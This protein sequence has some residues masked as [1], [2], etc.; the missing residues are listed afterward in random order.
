MSNQSFTQIPASRSFSLRLL[1]LLFGIL[2]SASFQESFAAGRFLADPVISEFGKTNIHIFT[3]PVV[4][5][6]PTTVQVTPGTFNVP[7][8][9]DDV[10]GDE[11]NSF[12]FE[13]VFDPDVIEPNGPNFGCSTAGTIAAGYSVACNVFPAGHLLV[14]VSNPSAG[15]LSGS[16]T[17][18]NIGFATHASAIDGEISPLTFTANSVK[19]FNESL[20]IVP[21]TPVNGQIT[22]VTNHTITVTQSPNGT[23]A[24]G[25]TVVPYGTNQ[26]FTITPAAN[27]HIAD[28]KVD[29]VSIGAV[30]NHPFFNVIADH[31]I[32]AIFAINTYPITATSGPNGAVTPPGI[33]NVPFGASQEYT[34]TPGPDYLIEDVLVD[35]VSVGAVASH[36][37][38]NVTAAH[39]ISATFKIK[40]FSL[41]VSKTG[42]GIGTVAS[43]A[44]GIDCGD[45]CAKTY[46]HGTVVTLTATP[47]TGS[48][49]TGWSGGGCSGT[50]TC[51]VTITAPTTVTATF[52]LQTF[53]L[54]VNR[55]GTGT[56]IVV[57]TPPGIDCSP[58][59]ADCFELYDY[60][61]VVTLTATPNI[62][63]IFTGW[64]G[65]CP[66]TGTC[67]VTMTS[68]KIVNANFTIKTFA[69]TVVSAGNGGGLVT[70]SP[71]G[72][73]CGAD[74]TATYN[75]GTQVT[76]TAV[77][78]AN[79]IFTGWSGA[80]S[81][82]STCVITMNAAATATAT[83]TL[84]TFD[85]TVIRSGTGEGSVTSSP[86]GINCGTDCSQTYNIGT[87]VTL[88]ATANSGTTF[89][90]WTG[91]GCTGTATC[92]VTMNAAA[93]VTATF[94]RI[95]QTL[96][97][98]KSGNGF[99]TITSSPAGINCG[100]N[101]PTASA[102]FPIDSQVTLTVAPNVG[103][104][105]T[106]WSGGGCSGT[107]TCVVT[108]NAATTV[109]AG[110]V[111]QTFPLSVVKAGTGA[112]TAT[113]VSTPAG[114]SCG[115]D[116]D[117]TYNFGSAIALTASTAPGTT[118]NGWSGAG[119]S[120]TGTCVVTVFSSL[121]VTATFTIQT[122]SLNITKS[123]NGSGVVTSD[124]PG[125]NCG[126]DCS[127]IYNIG[128]VVTL[129]A[130]PDPGTNF[131]GWSGG[132]CS[133]TGTC[134][135]TMNQMTVVTATFTLKI[136]S[137]IVIKEGNGTGTVTSSPS[138]I[139][140]GGDCA[141]PYN[142]GST[143]T[144]TAAPNA[145]SDFAGWNGGGCSG[146][147]T[148]VV[149]IT[150]A[151]S[152][153]ATFTL[154]TFALNVNKEGNGTGTI[155]SSPAGI[156]CG[157]DCTEI[158]NIATVVTLT[159]APGS[160]SSFAGWSGSGCSGTGTCV[161]TMNAAS[162]VT[163]TFN[164][165]PLVQFSSANFSGNESRTAI[166]TIT[167]TGDLSVNST[168]M[169][170]SSPGT[171][172]GGAVCAIGVDYVELS[173][174]VTFAPSVGVQTVPV[175]LC[176]DTDIDPFETINM[177]LSSPVSANIGA[178]NTSVVDIN[179]TANQYQGGMDGIFLFS[180]TN[181][182]PYPS[183]INAIDAPT[184]TVRVRVTLYDVWH[185]TPNKLKVLVVNPTGTK[186]VLMEAAG[187]NN[188][189]V[190]NSP[191]TLTFADFQPQILPAVGPLLTG[192]YKP[193]TC[194]TPIS[195]FLF[196]APS[197]PY[198]E[199]G[200]ELSEGPILGGAF[201][202]Q[203]LNG[204]WQLYLMDAGSGVPFTLA[205]SVTGG[206][207]LELLPT[208]APVVEISGQVF[209][210]GLLGL[211]NAV[212]SLTDSLGVRRNTPT[213]S[214]GFFA[215]SDVE[216]GKTY[217]LSVSSR[218]Y[219]FESRVLQVADNIQNLEIIGLE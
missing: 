164:A 55:I 202:G 124:L 149:T 107:G 72:I 110:F 30:S 58:S 210:V 51:Q 1:F 99:G 39:T 21:S 206:W 40:T 75:F 116:C 113:V 20:Q 31:T 197:G 105:F 76:L 198:L 68:N 92:E 64:N 60:G 144:L 148:C 188:P 118:F 129:T 120:G 19:F 151:T 62:N 81:G 157:G 48:N 128:T 178:Q 146:N 89:D 96:T 45:D 32:T 67:D 77:A 133:G 28:V 26:A 208:T 41:S 65:T 158:Y 172:N 80:C 216:A 181:A 50:G 212:V 209:T 3:P 36:T 70:S 52:T 218:R 130:A 219:R 186:Y 16:G 103:S 143:V 127:K 180:S 152:V 46:N 123:S 185:S 29:N 162:S 98:T 115:D 49:F 84:K 95:V 176:P 196:P 173:Q 194:L 201:S 11:I 141:K 44:P 140:C 57:S 163:A 138:G 134:I 63:S 167:R 207:G 136:H 217:I 184:G 88:T 73:N 78:N 131:V 47:S 160:G 9:V 106:G 6:A 112:A 195:N 179:D 169:L 142:H 192:A 83:F 190:S 126:T 111:L 182:E 90:G 38:Q 117:E 109:N 114:I 203:D 170:S 187:G 135:V 94:T 147:G 85:L 204:G 35:G 174:L 42:T 2:F 100:G 153:T 54:N 161:V 166:I 69:L 4:I 37:F 154:K 108:L 24:P 59:G 91:G 155:T 27:H 8:T 12:Q 10:T 175:S 156:G 71:S 101:C 53:S 33:T 213:S 177:S 215:F 122:F 61:T 79:S 159:A 119:C 13:L 150:E 214:L 87:D 18:L 22:L 7:I 193:T 56:G 97:V 17:I 139:N 34:I 23:I 200:C 168:V 189:V 137:L 199:P 66:G 25:T 15:V 183:V 86:P 93:S 102:A 171:A 74:C 145:N 14:S 43:V 5:T 82:T 205:G 125:V 121:S 165:F 132:G 104:N 191:V 211:R